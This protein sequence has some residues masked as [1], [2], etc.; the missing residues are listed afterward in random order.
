MVKWQVDQWNRIDKLKPRGYV[1]K[2]NG[3]API[4]VAQASCMQDTI[5]TLHATLE[6]HNDDRTTNEN[7]KTPTFH[8]GKQS[9]L[10]YEEFCKKFKSWTRNNVIKLICCIY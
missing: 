10:K 5:Q 1:A 7:L 9:Y 3:S 8:G 6:S 4:T 2:Q